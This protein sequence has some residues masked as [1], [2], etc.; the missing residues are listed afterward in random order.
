M[1]RHEDLKARVCAVIDAEAERITALSDEIMRNPES[2]FREHATARRVSEQFR[3]MGLPFRDG[4]AGTGVK[5]RMRARSSRH[6]VAVL[7]ELDS[8]LISDHP[9][10]DATTGA[11]HAC[12]HNAMIASMVGAGLGLQTVMDDLDGDVVLFAVPAEEC[13]EVDWRLARREAGDFE[14]VL[15][16]AELIRLGEF[17]D[18]DLALLTHTAA[19]PTVRS[20]RP[21]RR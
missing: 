7:G 3:D 4:L 10:A 12:G 17:D 5:T 14:F 18:V 8:L 13:I 9:F 6:T 16:K 1:P 21:G 11:A 20:R 19:R 2:G 15:G